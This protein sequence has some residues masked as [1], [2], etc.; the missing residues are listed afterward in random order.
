MKLP[1]ERT[2]R[3]APSAPIYKAFQ[4]L[5]EGDTPLH[6]ARAIRGFLRSQRPD[7]ASVLEVAANEEQ[8]LVRVG[9]GVSD[10][11]VSDL[12]GMLTWGPG[13]APAGELEVDAEEFTVQVT[14]LPESVEL[15]EEILRSD[16]RYFPYPECQ[17][18]EIGVGQLVLTA[19]RVLF[20]P[21]WEMPR[22]PGSGPSGEHVILLSTVRS[23]ARD[24]WWDI[25]C[26]MLET[27][28]R[29]YRYGWPAERGELEY[30]FDVDEWLAEID[31][32]RGRSG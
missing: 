18:F 7:L 29:V 11:A 31:R 21:R 4:E 3:I 20:E 30:L 32:V 1:S 10:E 13:S 25:P 23:T 8:V 2:W 16:V 5:A 9:G 12:R 17:W 22:E 19:T 28:L 14:S 6:V 24:E 27:E 26:L 15:E